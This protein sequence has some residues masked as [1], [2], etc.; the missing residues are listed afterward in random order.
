MHVGFGVLCLCRNLALKVRLL[1]K[2]HHDLEAWY[3]SSNE[4]KMTPRN[5]GPTREDEKL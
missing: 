3:K 4:V 5:P 2:V 1:V